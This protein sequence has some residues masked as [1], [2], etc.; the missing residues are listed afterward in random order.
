MSAFQISDHQL[1]RDYVT[2]A[3]HLQYSLLP[4]DVVAIEVSHSNLHA[5][6]LDI[7]LNLHSTVKSNYYLLFNI[8]FPN[9]VAM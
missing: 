5:K 4:E 9:L 6:H 8:Y 2:G 7:R 1:V 3:D